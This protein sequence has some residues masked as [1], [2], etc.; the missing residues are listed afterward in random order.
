MAL[1]Q[2]TVASCHLGSRKL[3]SSLRLLCLVEAPFLQLSMPQV[4]QETNLT[5]WGSYGSLERLPEQLGARCFC[6]K[7]R[8]FTETQS[9]KAKHA[10]ELR[11]RK[12]VTSLPLGTYTQ[13]GRRRRCPDHADM[14]KGGGV[15][16]TDTR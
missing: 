9:V 15:P 7:W 10:H 1:G 16:T 12:Q 13:T 11:A 5:L 2:T 3:P 8:K 4:P 6:C 14:P